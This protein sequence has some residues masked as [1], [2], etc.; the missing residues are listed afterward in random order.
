MSTTIDAA[1]IRALVEHIGMD[2]GSVGTGSASRGTP[3]PVSWAI[4]S[5][6]GMTIIM[7]RGLWG[8]HDCAHT[9]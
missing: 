1:I 4:S 8:S 6:E 2:P 3:I 5:A 7:L 9:S